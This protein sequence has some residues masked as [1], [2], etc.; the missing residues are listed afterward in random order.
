MLAYTLAL[1]LSTIILLLWYGF[2][3]ENSSCQR[4]ACRMQKSCILI[5]AEICTSNL[6]PADWKV[7]KSCRNELCI[8]LYRMFIK[9]KHFNISF[10]LCSN[11]NFS[12]FPK[13]GLGLPQFASLAPSTLIQN[14]FYETK[15]MIHINKPASSKITP[16]QTSFFV[17]PLICFVHIFEVPLVTPQENDSH[18]L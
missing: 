2:P 3:G 10:S 17:F 16:I 4:Y 18:F 1:C 14:P 9:V 6:N 7:R 13:H 12:R 11:I 8:L 15:S 5:L